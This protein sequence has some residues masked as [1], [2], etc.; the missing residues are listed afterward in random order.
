MRHVGNQDHGIAHGLSH[1]SLQRIPSRGKSLLVILLVFLHLLLL[2]LSRFPR[3]TLDPAQFRL[4]HVPVDL[5]QRQFHHGPLGDRATHVI[6]RVIFQD[7]FHLDLELPGE[8][9]QGLL[10]LHPVVIELIIHRLERLHHGNP[11]HVTDRVILLV[12]QR[13]HLVNAHAV[14]LAN[15]EKRLF[16]LHRVQVIGLSF[17]HDFFSRLFYFDFLGR[18]ISRQPQ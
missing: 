9:V 14:S 16:R 2:H 12:V 15:R 17:K 13:L 7:P 11:Q 4:Q 6:L 1:Q 3:L 8:R 10:R 18:D 5:L